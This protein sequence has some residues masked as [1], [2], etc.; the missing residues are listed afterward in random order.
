MLRLVPLGARE[1]LRRGFGFGRPS[2]GR[3]PRREHQAPQRRGPSD[4]PGTAAQV[5]GSG[6]SLR[7]AHWISSGWS[8]LDAEPE[9]ERIQPHIYAVNEDGDKPEKLR[10]LRCPRDRIPSPPSHAQGR[11]A[12]EAEHGFER[13]LTDGST[14]IR[15]LFSAPGLGRTTAGAVPRQ[16]VAWRGNIWRSVDPHAQPLHV[17]RVSEGPHRGTLLTDLWTREA[18]DLARRAV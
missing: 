1:I 15:A 4:V 12:A 13:V 6:D 8:W 18:S 5:H 9:I 2:R 16:A 17:S 14:R 3:R 11:P 10:I 7:P